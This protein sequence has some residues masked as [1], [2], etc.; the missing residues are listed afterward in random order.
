M[1]R[2]LFQR[3]MQFKAGQD[4]LKLFEQFRKNLKVN[5]SGRNMEPEEKSAVQKQLK[6]EYYD[7]LLRDLLNKKAYKLAQIIYGEKTREKFEADIKD[8]IIGMQIFSSQQKMEEYKEL[9][10]GLLQSDSQF[11]IDQQV[12]EEIGQT[13]Q[14]F[15][16]DEYQRDVLDMCDQLQYKILD[17]DITMTSNL[18]DNLVRQYTEAQSWSKIKSLVDSAKHNNCDPN[19]RIVGYLK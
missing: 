11:E 15:K 6:R 5:R 12:C 2:P 4:V 17:N 1:L 10:A 16:N 13:L 3:T 14:K 7:G 18:F 9:Y 19:P 8:Q